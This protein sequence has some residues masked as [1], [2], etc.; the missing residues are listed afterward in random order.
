MI[1]V[2]QG[3][4]Y[5]F[6]ILTATTTI[7]HKINDILTLVLYL[8]IELNIKTLLCHHLCRLILSLERTVTFYDL[9]F[10][11]Q[12]WSRLSN[13][14]IISFISLNY[15]LRYGLITMVDLLKFTA[16]WISFS[17]WRFFSQFHL[18][19]FLASKNDTAMMK[20]V[21]HYGYEACK[22]PVARWI[23]YGAADG[24]SFFF[25]F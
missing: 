3:K 15:F 2:L 12:H 23:M 8:S 20:D 16:V 18:V 21:I 13:M 10:L 5:N 19:C 1:K 17:M 9:H 25:M 14:S 4:I 11:Y 24:I 22:Y 7:Q 6:N